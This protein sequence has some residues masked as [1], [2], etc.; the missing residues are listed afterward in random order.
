MR[1]P[2]PT[3]SRDDALRLCGAALLAACAL[4]AAGCGG[5]ASSASRRHRRADQLR[6]ARRVGVDER[7]GD[8]RPVLLRHV[9]DV[10][11]APTSRSRSRA[12]APS[13]P[14]ASERRSPWTCR[15]SRSC[16]AASSQASPAP[17]RPTCR[18]STIRRAGRS[19][20]CRT[21]TSATSGFPAID[22]QLPDGK[23][24]IRGDAGDVKAGGFDFKELELVH[25]ERP[26][27]RA[28]GAP[29]AERRHR[30]RRRRS[31]CAA[32][33]RRTI[34]PCSTRPSSSR[35]DLRRTP[36]AASALDQLSQTGV[37]EVPLDVWIDAE[38]ARAEAGAR[39][40]RARGDERA[41]AASVSLAFELWDYGEHV[42]I[43]LPPASAGR[44]RV[45]PRRL[46]RGTMRA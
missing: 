21:A 46:A 4:V 42:E 22:G 37:G 32:S 45:R 15:R 17:T 38:R 27:R 41:L 24:W 12:R 2:R 44:R 19:R 9:V 6:A 16:S 1:E 3:S 23:T 31:S 5:G 20:S 34:A 25:A 39:C 10:R 43:D 29:R 13:T 30:D 36:D 26:A 11:R 33:R 7:R 14:R 18:T 8:E 35:G 40:R 28:R